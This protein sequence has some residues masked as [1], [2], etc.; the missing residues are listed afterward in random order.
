MIEG[1]VAIDA[2]THAVDVF[3]RDFESFCGKGTNMLNVGEYK[4]AVTTPADSSPKP[5][6][7]KGA[8]AFLCAGEMAQF[9][10][11]GQGEQPNDDHVV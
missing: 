7:T 2:V 4:A 1:L 10:R 11:L 3:I 6:L 9:L 5:R 8:G